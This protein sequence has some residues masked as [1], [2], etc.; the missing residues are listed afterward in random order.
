MAKP[1]P[2]R[3]GRGRCIF[4]TRQPPDVIISKEHVFGQWLRELFPRPAD[5]THT[6]G[7]LEWKS[8]PGRSIPKETNV[9]RQGHSGTRKIRHVCKHCNE[10]WLS[11]NVEKVA[12]PILIPLVSGDQVELNAAMQ[13]ILATWATK[14]AMT[15]EHLHPSKVV[16]HQ[17]ERT[18]L[19]KNLLPPVGW[20][21]WIG[22]YHGTAWSELAIRQHAGKL[23][24]P[25]IDNGTL[26][27]HNFQ[28]TILGMRRLVFVVVSSSWPQMQKVI[29]AL[30]A[31]ILGLSQIWPV[32]QPL[33]V[34]PNPAI[35]TDADIEQIPAHLPRVA[36]LSV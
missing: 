30:G 22:K 18:W 6:L 7:V 23:R 10:T 3:Y 12:Q 20:N 32:V 16:I 5:I 26:N 24:I 1:I 14:T 34:W 4:C 33:T 25:T 21:V 11:N 35:L 31:P 15:A 36:E 19:R 2:F 28:L 13:L 29:A 27:E 9:H 8:S 17:D